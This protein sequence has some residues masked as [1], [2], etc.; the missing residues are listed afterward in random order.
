MEGTRLFESREE[1]RERKEQMHEMKEKRK[2]LLEAIR[3]DPEAIKYV[4][5][6]M[7]DDEFI[8]DA[9]KANGECL[10]YVDKKYSEDVDVLISASKTKP[11][12]L[13]MIPAEELFKGRRWIQVII[14]MQQ[15][16]LQILKD[17][18][19]ENDEITYAELKEKVGTYLKG[20]REIYREKRKE[21]KKMKRADAVKKAS[22]KKQARIE[23]DTKKLK[24]LGKESGQ[25]AKDVE[26]IRDLVKEERL[27]FQ[28]DKMA[29]NSE[30]LEV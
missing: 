5:P 10:Y 25:I 21:Y 9:I 8:K 30:D 11:E 28:K 2:A 14:N 19:S 13:K 3:S 23:A 7:L 15:E 26:K 20:A 24:Q 29:A 27:A 6:E 18:K 1:R 16:A 17:A 4:D 22:A 12:F